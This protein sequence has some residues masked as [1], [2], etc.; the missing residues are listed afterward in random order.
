MEFPK[1]FIRASEAYNTFEH[2]VPA[3]YLRRAFQ[4]DHEAKAN[5]IITALGFYEL[6]LNG[7]RITKG[8]LAPYISNPD[9]LVYYDTYEVTLRAGENVLGVWLG[10]GFTNNPG[11]HIWDFDIAAFR[12]APQMA[13]CLTYTDKS[14]EAHCI[15]SDEMWRAESSP[16]LFDDYRFGEIYDGRLEIPGWNTIGFDDSAWKFAERA[17][18]PRGEK[19]LCTA[20]PIDIV[21]ELK[22]ISVTK[23]E[24]GYL[25]DFGINTAGVCRLCVRGELD[26][27]IELRHGEHLKDGLPDVE[28]IWFKRE[29]WARD[30]EYVHKDVYTCRGDGEEVYTPA[31]TYHGF[32][33]VLVSGITEAQATEDLLTALEMHSLLEERGGFSCSDE[34]ANK[35]QQMTRQSDVTNFYYFPTDCPQREKNGWTADAALSAEH[36]L[37][38][39]APE[40]CY[41]EWLRNIRG[42][43]APDGSLPGIVPTAGWG[44]AW[45]NGPAWDC[46]LF[47]LPYA[48]MQYRND[49]D[50]VRK[51]AHAMLRYLDYL[52]TKIRPDGLVA[53][54]L[55]DWCPAGRGCGDYLAPLELTDS[56]MAMDICRKAAEMFRRIGRQKQSAF[57]AEL[58]DA[59][60]QSIRSNLIDWETMLVKGNCQTSQAMALYFHVFEE[61]ECAQAF[62]RLMEIIE[63]DG[64]RMNVGVLGGRVLFHVLSAYGQS[65]LALHMITR[66]DFPSY[67]NWI[68]RGATTLWEEFQPE[69]DEVTSLNHHFW[70]NVSSWFIQALA[71]IRCFP[72]QNPNEIRIQPFFPDGMTFA[73]GWHQMPQGRVFVRWERADAQICLHIEVP[74]GVRGWIV[75]EDGYKFADTGTTKRLLKSGSFF[76]KD[77]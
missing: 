58:A 63:T 69:R 29:H 61:T 15:E 31:F 5:V 40:R 28:N 60:R 74:D 59:F 26:Q 46:V 49:L 9:D 36:T 20:E 42:S 38:Y 24:K 57:A 70:G 51:N 48:L 11:G 3:P 72:T 30:L 39:F 13:L 71:G 56:I 16:L 67:G 2:H 76:A 64:E 32:R 8:R 41:H 53:F 19:R 25:Y 44:F 10:N 54:G 22:P 7:E 6:Y 66:P 33:Y 12:A 18:Q 75:L 77:H 1:S 43:Q 73:E 34:T 21:N 4:A 14:G 45:G 62:A 55:G 35:L 68:V 65:A 52:T 37:L 17:P 50:A 27:R 47:W 23:T